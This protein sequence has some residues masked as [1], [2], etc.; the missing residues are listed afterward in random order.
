MAV[1]ADRLADGQKSFIPKG[2]DCVPG[3]C[4]TPFLIA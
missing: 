3:P 4:S 1:T 2:L